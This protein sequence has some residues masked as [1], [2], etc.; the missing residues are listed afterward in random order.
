MRMLVLGGTGF[1]GRTVAVAAVAAGHDVMITGRGET[2]SAPAGASFVRLDRSKGLDGVGGPFDS[3]VD[4]ASM[5][6]PWVEEALERI[7]AAHYTFVSS[8]N[9]YADHSVRGKTESAATL[10]PKPAAGELPLSDPD[11]YGAIKVACENAVLARGGLAIRAGLI[12]GP[13]DTTDR[14]G[15]WPARMSRGGSVVVPDVPEQPFQHIDA[16]DLAEWIVRMAA[17]GHGGVFNA[18]GPSWP[19]LDVL[20]QMAADFDVDLVPVAPAV[21]LERGVQPWAGPKSLPFWT[22]AGMDGFLDLNVSAAL[23]AGLTSRP[24]GDTVTAALETERRLGID[25]ERKAGLTPA[26]E[27]AL[28]R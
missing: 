10:A 27:A 19:L 28:L 4:V 14:F 8:V 21:L 9:A 16:R 13:G 20:A 12:T 22:P 25:R 2:G 1:L 26:E 3:V 17:A 15:Y 23:A 11:V 7:D 18:T 5:N 6:Y 24:F